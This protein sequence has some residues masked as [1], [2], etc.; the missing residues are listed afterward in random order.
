MHLEVYEQRDHKGLY[1]KVRA[2]ILKE[3]TGIRDPY[4][5]PEKPELV[6]ATETCTPEAAALHILRQLRESG[7]LHTDAQRPG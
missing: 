3:F 2:G 1:A 6:I 7:Y 5:A 4:E